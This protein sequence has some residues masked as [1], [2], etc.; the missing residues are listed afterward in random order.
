MHAVREDNAHGCAFAME[1]SRT[2]WASAGSPGTRGNPEARGPL[3]R[4]AEDHIARHPAAQAQVSVAILGAGH[5]GLALA[6]YLAQQGHRV[7]LWNRSPERIDPVAASGGI[8]LTLPGAAPIHAPI[9]VATSSIA[10]ALAGARRILVAVPATGHADIARICAPHLRGGQTVLLLPGRTGGAL[11]FQ[12]VLREAGCRANILLGEANTFP[13]AARSVGPAAAVVFGAKD[14][15][16]VAALPAARTAELLVAWR[17]ILPRLAAARSVLH[18]GLGNVGAILHPVITL[19]NADR[20]ARGD[21]FDFYRE[22]VTARVAAVL[23]AADAERLRIARAYGVAAC[24]LP[25]WIA[26]AYHH[27][28]DTM[29]EAVGGNPAYVGLKAPSTLQHRYLLEDVPTGLIPLIE[30]GR[31]AGLALPTLD[32]LVERA[33][34][35]LGGEHWGQPRHLD[36]LGLKGLGIAAIRTLV[37]R[38][39]PAPSF[40]PASSLAP[41]HFGSGLGLI[42]GIGSGVIA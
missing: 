8:R 24:S 20:I 40:K 37:E 1:K 38:G 32:G 2:R 19:L 4:T 11:E 34:D 22:G 18:T 6:G 3:A 23:A 21:S 10:T 42:P 27:H 41:E 9:A 28:G 36:S 33:R 5:G 7:A 15:A 39:L 16:L 30:L 17:P 25:A 14:E 13:L 29:Q 35:V 26:S 12:R 31:A